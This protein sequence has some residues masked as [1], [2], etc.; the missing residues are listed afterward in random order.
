MPFGHV[1]R[2][3]L[4]NKWVFLGRSLT[5]D[6]RDLLRL[7]QQAERVLTDLVG[8]NLLPSFP[9]LILVLLQQL[10]TRRNIDVSS[11]SSSYGFLYEALLTTALAKASQLKLDLD[12]Q[13]SY[14]AELAFHL[15]SRHSKILSKVEAYDWHQQFCRK[16]GLRLEF[17]SLSTTFANASVLAL[18]EGKVSFR[19]PYLYYYF[20]GRYFRDHISEETVR[21]HIREMSARLYHEESANVLI[22]LTYL[23]K[24]PLILD[25]ILASSHR[26]F[27]GFSDCDLV[28]DTHFLSQLIADI[29]KLVIEG[30]T[31]KLGGGNSLQR[32]T[33]KAT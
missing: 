10:E 7:A 29:P 28:K 22:F 25:E 8:K 11:T 23:S 15:F 5:H 24:D 16:F 32:K 26:L 9:L 21:F 6:E 30:T 1:K 3:D 13:Y 2:S 31:L 12:T 27:D 20:L 14:L 4:V 19:Y 33:L 17:E 18:R